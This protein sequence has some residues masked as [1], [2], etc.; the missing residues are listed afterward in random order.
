MREIRQSGSEG[1]VV[2]NGHP[3]PY[4]PRPSLGALR[5]I[6][7]L[8]GGNEYDGGVDRRA[9]GDGY[10]RLPEPSLVSPEKAGRGVT[11]IKN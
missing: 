9:S 5:G 8:V 10:A 1:G 6:G 7:A 11:N 4:T 3:Y 2:G